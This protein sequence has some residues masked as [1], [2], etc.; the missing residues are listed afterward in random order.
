[1]MDAHQIIKQHE[2]KS[3]EVVENVGGNIN[4]KFYDGTNLVLIDNRC[5][6]CGGYM[7]EGTNSD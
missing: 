7:I 3:I 5:N 1:M 2:G 6:T 4:I